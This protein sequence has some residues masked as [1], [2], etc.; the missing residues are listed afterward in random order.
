MACS[1]ETLVCEIE[2]VTIVGTVWNAFQVDKERPAGW[3][4]KMN[5]QRDFKSATRESDDGKEEGKGVDDEKEEGQ[6]DHRE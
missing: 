2:Q 1:S 5:G 6:E 4:P 3:V